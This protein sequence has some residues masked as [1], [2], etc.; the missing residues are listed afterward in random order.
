MGSSLGTRISN[1]REDVGL[2]LRKLAEL[3]GKS[4]AFISV[5]ENSD[6]APKVSEETL[7]ELARVLSLD[8][9]ELLGLAGR[10]PGDAFPE[11]RLD[12]A[13]YRRV[14]SLSDSRKKKLLRD[15]DSDT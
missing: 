8:V 2:S 9:D 6:P 4:P 3:V 13:L 10:M 12:V 15:L 11:S 5:L 7:V 1:A 14:H